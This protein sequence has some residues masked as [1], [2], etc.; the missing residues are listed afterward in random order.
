MS[1]KEREA[2]LLRVI[3][4]SAFSALSKPMTVESREAVRDRADVLLSELEAAV[5]LDGADAEI[6]ESIAQTRRDIRADR[7]SDIDRQA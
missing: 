2:F 4:V 5:R 6:L 7:A 1:D 3:R